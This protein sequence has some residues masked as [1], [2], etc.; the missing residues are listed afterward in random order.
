M[1]MCFIDSLLK[2]IQC[3][4]TFMPIICTCIIFHMMTCSQID[5]LCV[6]EMIKVIVVSL[7]TV[8]KI[9]GAE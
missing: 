9:S 1:Y 4:A 6:T 8:M 5:W 2:I 7:V 3:T